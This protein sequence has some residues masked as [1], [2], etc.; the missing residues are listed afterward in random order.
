[1]QEAISKSKL[2]V[3]CKDFSDVPV[4]SFFYQLITVL[5][6]EVKVKRLARKVKQWFNETQCSTDLHYRFTGR[7]SRAF[8]H[9]FMRVIK[10]LSSAGDSKKEKQTVLT[11]AYLGRRQRDC[12]SL[13]NRFDISLEEIDQLSVA[14]HEYLVVNALFMETSVNPTVWT[15]GHVVPAHCKDVFSK[16]GQGLGLVTMEGREA[17]HIF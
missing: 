6:R 14:C 9:N 17:K 15:L 7:E 5:Q 12:V 8:C 2:P 3:S 10:C 16:Y 11:L 13:F 4:N 1:M